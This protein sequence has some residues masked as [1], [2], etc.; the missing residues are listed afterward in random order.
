L[1]AK[2]RFR[3]LQYNSFRDSSTATC[4]LTRGKNCFLRSNPLSY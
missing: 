4:G 1:V 3:G 2:A